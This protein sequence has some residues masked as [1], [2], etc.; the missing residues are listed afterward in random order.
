MAQNNYNLFTAPVCLSVWLIVSLSGWLQVWM[1]LCLLLNC[2]LLVRKRFWGQSSKKPRHKLCAIVSWTRGHC[3]RKLNSD[4]PSVSGHPTYLL[5][6]GGIC[7]NGP[8][9][10]RTLGEMGWPK[11]CD[12]IFV[13]TNRFMPYSLAFL[14]L[15]AF[16][17]LGLHCRSPKS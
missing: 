1:S 10:T 3:I 4:S 11:M 12:Y 14:S 6:P 16:K 8:N 15:Y 17:F 7:K 13:H 2:Q 5:S 9:S